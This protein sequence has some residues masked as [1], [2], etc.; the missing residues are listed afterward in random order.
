MSQ[1]CLNKCKF[2]DL[3]IVNGNRARKK[4]QLVQKS[5]KIYFLLIKTFSESS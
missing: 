1:L 2:G 4:P 5:C 3:T